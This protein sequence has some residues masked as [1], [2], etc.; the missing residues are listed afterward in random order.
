MVVGQ[1]GWT[2]GLDN[3]LVILVAKLLGYCTNAV[4]EGGVVSLKV[5]SPEPVQRNQEER[6]VGTVRRGRVI[7]ERYTKQ[8]RCVL[9]LLS[10]SEE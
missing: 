9:M 10:I 2:K 7:Q 5:T 8:E 3:G 4:D 6:R 1:R